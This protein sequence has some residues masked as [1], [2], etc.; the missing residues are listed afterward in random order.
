MD[1]LGMLEKK[2]SAIA[3]DD[4]IVRTIG[5]QILSGGD[6]S[7]RFV[8]KLQVVSPLH[9][10]NQDKMQVENNQIIQKKEWKWY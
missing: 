2:E 9:I 8:E 10:D 5:S 7:V 1:E 3:I 4:S 6:K